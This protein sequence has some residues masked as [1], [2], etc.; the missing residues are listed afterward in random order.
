[1][2]LLPSLAASDLRHYPEQVCRY[3]RSMACSLLRRRT[4][5]N[6]RLLQLPQPEADQLGRVRWATPAT[7]VTKAYRKL[8]LLV[9]N[10]A[11]D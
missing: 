3:A 4:V 7:D 5:S 10:L 9:P 6:C 1:M 11:A 2:Y 8:S